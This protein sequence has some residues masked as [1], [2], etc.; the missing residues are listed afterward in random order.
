M[1]GTYGRVIGVVALA[2]CAGSGPEEQAV[3]VM[4]A[5]ALTGTPQVVG[6]DVQ[7]WVQFRSDAE[8]VRIVGDLEPEIAALQGHR[9]RIVGD[10]PH[11]PPE[12]TPPH[13]QSPAPHP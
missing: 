7:T 8:T 10:S 13:A 11:R 3:P 5:R 12:P 6:T 2:A 4:A 1:T 9:I